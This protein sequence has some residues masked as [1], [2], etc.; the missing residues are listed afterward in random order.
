M[1][2]F[3]PLT[4]QIRLPVWGTAANFNGCRVLAS[5]LLRRRSLEANQILHDVWSSPALL[6]Y[7]IH[8]RGPLPPN[9]ILPGAEFT[10]RP[11]LAFSYTSLIGSVI[12]KF[13]Y[14]SWFGACSELVR[15][16]ACSEPVRSQLQTSS[17][18]A[19]N[20]LRTS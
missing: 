3:G 15:L 9:G 4:A 16:L 19:P 17:E 7:Y 10:L 13:H 20:Q 2:N 6:H 8:F 5:L 18:L 14:A 11:S 12:A 1:A